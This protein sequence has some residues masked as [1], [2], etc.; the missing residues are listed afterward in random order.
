MLHTPLHTIFESK[1]TSPGP[2]LGLPPEE[3][4][5]RK[6]DLCGI[7]VEEDLPPEEYP[8]RKTGVRGIPIVEDLAQSR[9]D[10]PPEEYPPRKVGVRGIPLEEG[11]LQQQERHQRVCEAAGNSSEEYTKNIQSYMFSLWGAPSRII[12]CGTPIEEFLVRK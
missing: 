12:S 10:L 5:L 6:T 11:L 4:P 3:Y 7:P 1:L 8:S 2:A 9:E